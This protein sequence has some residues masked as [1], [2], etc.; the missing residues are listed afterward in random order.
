M[1]DR[2]TMITSQFA[3]ISLEDINRRAALQTRAD[4]KYF[5]PWSVFTAFTEMM[6][7]THVILEINGQRAFTYDTQYFDTEDLGCYWDHVQ[8]RRKRFKCRSRRYVDNGQYFF[9]LKLKGGRD[10]TVKHKIAYSEEEWGSV[11]PTASSFLE[12]RLR[13]A[14][15]IT[16]TEPLV[17][18]LRTLYQRVTFAAEDGSE[19]ITCDFNLAF[20][21]NG[22]WQS[23]L[24]ENYVLVETKSERGRGNADKRIWSLGERPAVGSKYC[25]GLSLVKPKLRSNAFQQTRKNFFIHEA[26][27]ATTQVSAETTSALSARSVGDGRIVTHLPLPSTASVLFE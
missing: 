12:N 8:K 26:L 17:P 13:E 11:T 4:N 22:G 16:L 9:E 7:D 18:T 20:G 19:R 10:E 14:Y 27:P 25:V 5:L 2:I 15:G 1:S 23:R 24:A 6:R 3:P 21:M